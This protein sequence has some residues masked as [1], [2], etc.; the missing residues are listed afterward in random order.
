MAVWSQ[1]VILFSFL[2]HHLLS[3][4]I[5]VKL[6]S[7][8]SGPGLLS[9]G[10]SEA[11]GQGPARQLQLWEVS[12]TPH[13]ANSDAVHD[14]WSPKDQKAG[15]NTESPT[16]GITCLDKAKLTCGTAADWSL[17][18]DCPFLEGWMPTLLKLI[19]L[20]LP[21]RLWAL[22]PWPAYICQFFILHCEDSLHAECDTEMGVMERKRNQPIHDSQAIWEITKE[23][24]PA[25]L[26]TRELA[27]HTVWRLQLFCCWLCW[28]T[29][30][31]THEKF[32]LRQ[33]I[34]KSC[35]DMSVSKLPFVRKREI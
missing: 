31:V 10:L 6:G 1:V 18:L 8:C 21:F 29:P 32:Y 24:K 11:C 26:S 20:I 12:Q 34:K 3:E 7:W 35:E 16:G 9:W 17:P 14:V 33:R 30:F 23:E 25:I 2:S 19:T 13:I 22:R 27:K 4:S 15:I 5:N 28:R